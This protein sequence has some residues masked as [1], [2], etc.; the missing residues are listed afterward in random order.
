MMLLLQELER[1]QFSSVEKTANGHLRQ[2]QSNNIE[3][4]AK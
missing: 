4:E 1:N 2:L 3:L